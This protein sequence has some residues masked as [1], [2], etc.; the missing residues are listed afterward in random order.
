MKVLAKHIV[1]VVAV[2]LSI[3]ACSP[4]SD[5]AGP[6]WLVGNWTLTYNPGHDSRDELI[7]HQDGTVAII[8][9]QGGKLQGKYLVKGKQLK[10]VVAT[11]KRAVDVGFTIADDHSKLI[12]PSSGAYYTGKP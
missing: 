10:L 7:F 4:S 1:V 9:E 12:Y 5:S 2:A 6:G 3:C 11:T 8:T